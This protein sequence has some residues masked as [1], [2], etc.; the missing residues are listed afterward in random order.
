MWQVMVMWLHHVVMTVGD[1]T[2]VTDMT[3]MTDMLRILLR[4]THNEHTFDEHL[5][6]SLFA[7]C[8]PLS[9]TTYDVVLCIVMHCTAYQKTSCESVVIA[10]WGVPR[11]VDII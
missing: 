6:V 5:F 1:M 9:T 11:W 8:S 3:D 10:T 7:F 4:I 2:D